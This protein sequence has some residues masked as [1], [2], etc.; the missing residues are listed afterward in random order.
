MRVLVTGGGGFLGSG[1]AR[2]LHD[3]K[4][5]VTV[6]GRNFYPHLPKPIKQFQGDIRDFDFL[7][8]TI[9]GKDAVF[10]TAAFPG[11]W[12][13]AEDFYSVNVDGTRNIIKSCL[14]SGVAK[15]IFTSSPSVIYGN[16]NLEGVDESVPYPDD[17][18]C[19]YPRTKA[20][21]EKLVIE[22]NG[23]DLATVSLRPHLI[24]GPGDPHLIPRLLAKADKGRLV[25][26]GKGENKVDIIYIDNAVHAHLKACDALG[27]G[28]PTAGKVYFVSD[29]EPVNLWEWINEVLKKTNRVPVSRS[30]S[31]RTASRLGCFFES[32]YN[33]ANIKNEPLMTR[34]LASQ[35]ATS[36]YFNI[37]RAR[38]DLGYEPV[39]SP[40]EGLHRLIQSL[41]NPQEY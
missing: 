37:S 39:V 26:V 10:H 21:A 28:K 31:Y 12:G 20:L 40:D 30:I 17:Y 14:L 1:I 36:H 27:F 22:A 6:I 34:F 18:L 7:R 32:I 29:G 41:S 16:S 13:R 23:Q 11:I 9:A 2:A 8:K 35:L 15:L 25:R 19:E 3:K 24:W 33:W 4:H 38:K 5:D